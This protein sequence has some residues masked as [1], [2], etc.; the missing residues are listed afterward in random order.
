MIRSFMTPLSRRLPAPLRRR[1][2]ARRAL[3]LVGP[4]V[5]V[6]IAANRKLGSP[7]HFYAQST[8][9]SPALYSHRAPPHPPYKLQTASPHIQR[10]SPTDFI[11]HAFARRIK[12]YSLDG[13]GRRAQSRRW[14]IA[15]V[16]IGLIGGA[17]AWLWALNFEAYVVASE[18]VRNAPEA[19]ARFGAINDLSLRSFRLTKKDGS[20]DFAVKGA[21]ANGRALLSLRKRDEWFVDRMTLEE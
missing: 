11:R 5:I 1:S 19:T 2:S 12:S 14:L 13:M 18:Y 20:I 21:N 10:F 15:S 17:S 3:T 8:A 4:S 9:S 16:A 6:A 7:G